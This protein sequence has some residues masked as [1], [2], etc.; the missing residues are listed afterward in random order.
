MN[1]NKNMQIFISHSTNDKPIARQIASSLKEKSI[2]VWL[3]EAEI[4]VGESIPDKVSEGILSSEVLCILISKNSANSS[5]VK[6]ELNA[7]MPRFIAGDSTLL[8]CKLDDT[9]PPALISDIKYADFSIDYSI[10]MN[11]LLDAVR[12]RDEVKINEEA[13]SIADNVL[14]NFSNAEIAYL[15][16]DIYEKN[17][18]NFIFVGDRRSTPAPYDLLMKLTSLNALNESTDRYEI[19]YTFTK[20]GRKAI[21]QIYESESARLRKWVENY[22]VNSEE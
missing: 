18:F 2:N 4:R 1:P 11:S 20:A 7:F 12:V 9:D 13:N 5:W 10:G 19:L 15:L 17:N 6:R 16:F 21:K 14:S 3:D 22:N 8:P